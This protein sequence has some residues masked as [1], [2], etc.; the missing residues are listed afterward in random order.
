MLVDTEHWYFTA[1]ERA[2]AEIGV[3]LDKEQYLADMARGAGT[4]AQARAAGVDC[5]VVDN[6]FTASQD[7][8]LARHRIRTLAELRQILWGTT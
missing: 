6:E 2:L 4:W 5:A 7:F 8:S 1:G 3:A